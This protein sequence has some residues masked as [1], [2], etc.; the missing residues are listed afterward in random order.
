[1]KTVVKYCEN[2]VRDNCLSIERRYNETID[3]I[4]TEINIVI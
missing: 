3:V 2:E 4:I 1:M